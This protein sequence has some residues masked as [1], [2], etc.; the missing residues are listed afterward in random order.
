M[1][2]ALENNFS[3]GINAIAKIYYIIKCEDQD[4]VQ[5]VRPDFRRANVDISLQ[6]KVFAWKF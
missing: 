6:N 2:Q 5:M 3:L 4:T 1:N